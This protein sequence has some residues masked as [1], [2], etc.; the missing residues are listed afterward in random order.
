MDPISWPINQPT[1]WKNSTKHVKIEFLESLEHVVQQLDRRNSI[2]HATAKHRG[3][4]LHWQSISPWTS[5]T[6]KRWSTD[7]KK[8]TNADTENGG[9]D[10]DEEYW[11]R[12]GIAMGFGVGFLGVVSPLLFCRFWREAYYWFIQEYLW[13]KILDCF[14][15]IKRMGRNQRSH[16]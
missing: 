1:V 2:R 8:S 3:V 13:Y 14:I 16:L 12:L 5:V 11:F 9:E 4:W 6:Q 10:D 7:D 15:K